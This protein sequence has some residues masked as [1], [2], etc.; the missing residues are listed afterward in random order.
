MAASLNAGPG[1]WKP[2][3]SMDNSP[4]SLAQGIQN[5]IF[6]SSHILKDW[7]D[8]LIDNNRF[9]ES[10]RQKS[11]ARDRDASAEDDADY[12]D[13]DLAED[14][15]DGSEAGSPA[16]SRRGHG[17][18]SSLGLPGT[19]QRNLMQNGA[20]APRKP[21][22]L[23]WDSDDE[24]IWQMKAE[25]Y[26]DEPIRDRLVEENRTRYDAKTIAT[27]YSRM[28]RMMAAHEEQTLDDAFSDFHEHEVRL[29]GAR[30]LHH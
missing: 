8:A 10:R 16:N 12:D 21:V 6:C 5:S 2:V 17:R 9:T 25:G 23:D 26:K 30:H 18:V 1:V 28:R 29:V 11:R 19:A 14:D 7:A 3:F 20:T 24:I 27:R 4:G 13:E 15:D 22:H